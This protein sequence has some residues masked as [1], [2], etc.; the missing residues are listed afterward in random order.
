MS[1]SLFYVTFTPD[2]ARS[3]EKETLSHFKNCRNFPV[4]TDDLHKQVIL[5]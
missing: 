4:N 2:M 3:I 5:S 1:P